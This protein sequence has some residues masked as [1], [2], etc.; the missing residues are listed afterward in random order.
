MLY[1]CDGIRELL[2]L[3]E[4]CIFSCLY[5]SS[6]ILSVFCL[7]KCTRMTHVYLNGFRHFSGKHIQAISNGH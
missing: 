4:Y 6:I 5:V 2:E 7:L 1:I 3:L